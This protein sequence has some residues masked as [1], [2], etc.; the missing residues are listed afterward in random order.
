M[1]CVYILKYN[2]AHIKVRQH[3]KCDDMCFSQSIENEYT[4]LE[5]F[6]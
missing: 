6:L 5:L 2:K 1:L 4:N 3:E